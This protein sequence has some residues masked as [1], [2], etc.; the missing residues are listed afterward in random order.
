[1]TVSPD[2]KA[3]AP[4]SDA[5]Q[6][7]AP[8]SRV[9]LM[10]AGVAILVVALV[11]LGIVAMRLAGQQGA[12]PAPGMPAPDFD[13]PL[14]ANYQ[15]NLGEATKLSDLRGK[16][17]IINFWA[18]WCVPCKDEA[19]ALE[20]IAKKYADKDVVLLGVNYLDVERDALAFLATY[21]VTYGN[22][23]DLQQRISRAYRITGVPETFVIDQQGVVSDVFIQPITESQ[24][25]ATLDKLLN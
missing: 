1:M 12:R 18:S 8:R 2:V 10:V 17:V 3:D 23:V 13:L 5:P 14:Y 24:L 22:G 6:S 4:Q 15:N 9:P 20:K 25:S 7:D 16:V 21:D 11:A 19:P